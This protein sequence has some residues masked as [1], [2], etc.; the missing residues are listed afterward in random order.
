VDGIP[1]KSHELPQFPASDELLNREL[2]KGSS[3]PN[4]SKPIKCGV[5]DLSLK[6]DQGLKTPITLPSAFLGL[7]TG[8]DLSAVTPATSRNTGGRTRTDT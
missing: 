1:N 2:V 3:S 7:K 5:R 8:L 4:I 6:I